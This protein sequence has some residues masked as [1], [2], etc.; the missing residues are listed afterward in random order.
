MPKLNFRP[1]RDGF[2]FSNRFENVILQGTPAKF[3]TS[4]LCGGMAMSALD[5]WRAG[6]PVPTH[7][8]ED[9]G[10][11][12][13]PADPSRLRSYIYD[14]QMHSLLTGM[15]MTRWVVMPWFGPDDF[16][17]WA[18][19]SEFAV[20]RGQVDRGRPAVLGLWSMEPGNLTGG[21]QV[22]CYGYD[23]H[24]LR[25]WVYDPNFPDREMQLV[26][27]SADKGCEMQ[28][29]DGVCRKRYRGYFWTDVY[30]WNESPYQPRYHDLELASGL[31]LSPGGDN[32]PVGGQLDASVV[33]RNA[34]EYPARFQNLYVWTRGP[35]GANLDQLLGGP[36]Q[37]LTVLH[38]GEQ[39]LMN[40]RC[41]AFGAAPG[42]YVVGVSY[43]SR[44]D[45]W[46]N[47]TRGAPGTTGQRQVTLRASTRLLVDKTVEV[48]EGDADVDSGVDVGPGQEYALSASG[49]I[50]AGVWFTGQNG[51]EGWTDKI[52]SSPRFPLNNQ[53][54]AHPFALIARFHGHPYHYVGNGYGR[55]PYTSAEPRRLTLRINDD[56][57]G[58]GSGSFRCRIQ[59]W[60]P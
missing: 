9:F 54:R 31:T 51:P 6:T 58:N 41:N 48:R 53:P 28:D 16:H 2:H 40:R 12:Q 23:Y 4:G 32:V 35:G 45:N 46:H 24:P 1:A 34:G 15:A 17:S 27:V 57:P 7:R 44:E 11:A 22:L 26:P 25:L 10:S 13:V 29:V 36:E 49:S 42:T 14:R 20:V 5:Y 30:N 43:L 37:G 60:G 50:W 21:H 3:S 55:R 56:V 33:V 52:E 8:G 19:G 39:R 18:T 38:P 59:V 47:I